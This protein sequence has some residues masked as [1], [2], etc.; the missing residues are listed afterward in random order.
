MPCRLIQEKVINKNKEA[1]K[2][3]AMGSHGWVFDQPLHF[4]Y[5]GS[6]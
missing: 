3:S 4:E 1:L 2:R 5:L 6:N